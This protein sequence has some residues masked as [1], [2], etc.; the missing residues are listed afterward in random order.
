MC[1]RS[2]NRPGY[3]GLPSLIHCSL[4][5][6]PF[7]ALV[8][9]PSIS[10]FTP[11]RSSVLAIISAQIAAIVIGRP[12]IEP[13]LSISKVTIVSLNFISFSCLYESGNKG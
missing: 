13:E 2:F 6:P 11:H 1:L 12:L 5:C 3:D 10:T 4:D 9:K 8:V 7:Q